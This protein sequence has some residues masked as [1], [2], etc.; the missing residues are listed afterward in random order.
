MR[1]KKSYLLTFILF[2]IFSIFVSI[3]ANAA[4]N[5]LESLDINVFINNDGSAMI[6]EKRVANLIEGKENY[7]VIDNLGKSKIND[8]KVTENGRQYQFIDSWNIDES[9]E[10]KA[11]KNGIIETSTGYELSWGIGEYGSHEYLLEYTVT[12]FIK[13]LQDSQMLFWRFQNDQ[14]NI[15][16][17]EVTVTVESETPLN[18]EDQKV[19]GFGFEGNVEFR[20][21]KVVAESSQP[22]NSSN[23]VTVLLKLEKGMFLTNDYVDKPF[24]EVKDQAF[25]G[26]SY[27]D[28]ESDGFFNVSKKTSIIA[29][30]LTAIFSI[31]FPLLIVVVIIFAV[32]N[33]SKNQAGT[34]K[35]RYKEEYYRDYPYEGEILDIYYIFFKMGLSNFNNMLTGCLLKWINEDKIM[36]MSEETGVIIKKDKTRIKILNRELPDEPL[37]RELFNMLLS[38]SGGD[39]IL[40]EKEFTKWASKNYTAID[41]WE[42]RAKNSSIE[43]LEK[44]GYLQTVT[45]KK[46]FMNFKE[47]HL[48]P[49]GFRL[50][51]NIYKYINYLYDYSLLNEN[52]AVNVKIWDRIMI[53]AG[54]LGIAEVV[55]KQFDKLYPQYRVETVYTG[56]SIYLATALTQNVSAA[57]TSASTRAS[58]GMGG[59]TS[60]GGGG[61]SFGG[62]SGGGTR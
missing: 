42:K 34:F 51:E 16:P 46:F 1:I 4:S 45:K 14:T 19:W 57:R 11:F 35:R 23:Y 5:E 9:R 38:A 59:S 21:G 15:P 12:D 39:N 48:T 41:S 49:S 61:G 56:N 20:D 53:W 33:I 36:T 25:E 6:R 10:N 60:I 55:E 13:E 31:I 29:G 62:G 52:E 18:E 58:S 26:S 7:I 3:P 47:Q 2:L 30:V 44:L 54:F 50:E 22:L 8:F 43:K 28:N 37:E 40:Q 27:D 32:R 24:E 17:K